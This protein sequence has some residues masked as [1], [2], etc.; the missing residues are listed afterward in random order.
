[1]FFMDRNLERR[2][3]PGFFRKL[4]FLRVACFKNP[5]RHSFELSDSSD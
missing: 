2:K 3:V 5:A 4:Q 1:M